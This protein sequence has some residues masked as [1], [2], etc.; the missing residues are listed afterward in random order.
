MERAVLLSQFFLDQ[1]DLITITLGAEGFD[2]P[3]Q[4]AKLVAKGAEWRRDHGEEPVP[5]DQLRVWCLPER[6]VLAKKRR[7]WLE[8]TVRQFPR[9]GRVESTGQSIHWF[10]AALG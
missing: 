10:P 6:R 8:E 5:L 1:Y 7:A 9:I 3:A 4:V 2:L